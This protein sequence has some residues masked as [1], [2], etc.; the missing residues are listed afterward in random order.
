MLKP[1][2]DPES[3]RDI[4]QEYKNVCLVEHEH[5]HL[6]VDILQTLEYTYPQL[7]LNKED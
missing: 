7:T 6:C 3:K 5:R 1:W 4:E 2:Q